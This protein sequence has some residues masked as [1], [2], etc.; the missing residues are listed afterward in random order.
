MSKN[1]N[2]TLLFPPT[3]V[4]EVHLAN[5]GAINKKI[6]GGIEKIRKSEPIRFPC[7]GVATF[8]QPSALPLR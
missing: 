7:H 4:R 5:A 8:T 2:E 1:K 3:V 6:K